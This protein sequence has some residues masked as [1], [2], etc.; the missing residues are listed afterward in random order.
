M[1]S[2]PQERTK[3]KIFNDFPNFLLTKN[4][5][6][7]RITILLLKQSL[8]ADSTGSHNHAITSRLTAL[9]PIVPAT[10]GGTHTGG[11]L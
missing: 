2:V 3:R 4:H 8:I 11:T 1:P 10:V 7:E 9:I 5:K 6:N